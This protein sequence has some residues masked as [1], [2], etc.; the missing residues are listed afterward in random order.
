LIPSS[1]IGDPALR[2]G[3]DGYIWYGKQRYEAVALHQPEF[4]NAATAEF[5]QSV[6]TARPLSIVLATGRK[7]STPN[8][9]P[10]TRRCRRVCR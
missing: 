2:V 4:E 5:F 1:E 6:R 8:R 3:K 10:E 7:T 9:S